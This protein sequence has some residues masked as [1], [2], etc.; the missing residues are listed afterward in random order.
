MLVL[1]V[2][3]DGE[4]ERTV[5]SLREHYLRGRLSVEE[6]TERLE[7]ALN[8]RRD[9]DVRVALTDLPGPSWHQAKR[10]RA[11]LEETWSAARRTAFL[12]AVWM[13]W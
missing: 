4:R 3:G 1:A 13:L 12:V 8:A 7:V 6:L 2:I 11:S 5:E 10:F 9:R